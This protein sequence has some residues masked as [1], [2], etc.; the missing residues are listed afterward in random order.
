MVAKDPEMALA[1]RRRHLPVALELFLCC[2]VPAV[3]LSH[4]SDSKITYRHYWNGHSSKTTK[5][6]QRQGER[7]R[8]EFPPPSSG[9]AAKPGDQITYVYGHRT[10][11][12]Y[13]CDRRRVID[14]DLDAREYATYKLNRQ[15]F[16]THAKPY[17]VE[18]SGGTLTVTIETIDTGERKEVFGYTARHI[19]THQK[20]VPG[21]TAISRLCRAL[22]SSDPIEFFPQ[23]F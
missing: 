9:Y 16:P 8:L 17:K 14:L 11:T 6:Y 4:G 12:I 2:L 20:Q 1:A 22:V 21:P 7:S 23:P 13:Q 3:M 18:P 15:G 19:I 5:Y 10:V